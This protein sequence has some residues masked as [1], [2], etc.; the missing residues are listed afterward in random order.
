MNEQ[1]ELLYSPGIGFGSIGLGTSGGVGI[2]VSD[3]GA[4][5]KC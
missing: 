5:T 3:D 1:V 2:V 4:F